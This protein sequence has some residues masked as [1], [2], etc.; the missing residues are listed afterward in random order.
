MARVGRWLGHL[1]MASCNSGL[2]C[3]LPSQ[4]QLGCMNHVGQFCQ[5]SAKLHAA[6]FLKS[7]LESISA[8]MAVRGTTYKRPLEPL[9]NGVHVKAA[10]LAMLLWPL[11]Y[12]RV[13]SSLPLGSMMWIFSLQRA[14]TM[15]SGTRWPWS[16]LHRKERPGAS[17]T[18]GKVKG[19]R[20][21]VKL[22]PV[23]NTSLHWPFTGGW[24]IPES[25]V[26]Q[27]MQVP[28][29]GTYLV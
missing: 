26:S 3:H 9:G 19:S 15:C 24:G 20:D 25:R 10:G 4:G 14:F 7:I 27:L 21:S 28:H 29:I 18:L 5:K 23:W 17:D 12:L 13:P 16:F 22:C 6:H 2:L 1:C 8:G 11:G